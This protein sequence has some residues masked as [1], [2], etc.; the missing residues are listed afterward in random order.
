MFR[1][2]AEFAP[3]ER[4]ENALSQINDT[5]YKFRERIKRSG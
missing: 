3:S 5:K 4:D 1:A 2:E